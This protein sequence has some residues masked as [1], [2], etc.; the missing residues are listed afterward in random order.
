[1]LNINLFILKIHN[2]KMHPSNADKKVSFLLI[3]IV[4]ASILFEHGPKHVYKFD[5]H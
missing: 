3:W 4:F 5:K 2:L 1:M